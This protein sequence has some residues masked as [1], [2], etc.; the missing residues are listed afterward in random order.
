MLLRCIST[1]TWLHGIQRFWMKVRRPAIMT[2]NMAGDDDCTIVL[3][4]SAS[5]CWRW[6]SVACFNDSWELLDDPRQDSLCSCCDSTCKSRPRRGVHL[7]TSFMQCWHQY[8][9]FVFT[10]FS[11]FFFFS[12]LLIFDLTMFKNVCS[13][14]FVQNPR[15]SATE[16]FWDHW[17][18]WIHLIL[19]INHLPVQ[20]YE[21]FA[22]EWDL[23]FPALY[24]G[25]CFLCLARK[26]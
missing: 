8:L 26:S 19:Q 12:Y 22:L 18:L 1:A 23:V 13:P 21:V 20:Q 24:T 4:F 2:G 17:S 25:L 7:G 10:I 5:L 14:L 6:P 3:K 15:G 9:N 16:L 11:L